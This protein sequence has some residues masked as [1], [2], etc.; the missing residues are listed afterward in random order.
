MP[1]PAPTPVPTPAPTPAPTPTPVNSV[2][3][4]DRDRSF[5]TRSA[6]S[7]LTFDLTAGTATGGTT[8]HSSLAISYNADSQSYTVAKG[9]VSSSFGQADIVADNAD[10]L[11]FYRQMGDIREY[12]TLV[13][14]P[15][16]GLPERKHVALGYWQRNIVSSDRQSM[17]LAT[18][19]YGLP[20]STGS[21]PRSGSAGYNIDAFGVVSQPGKEP[22]TLFGLGTFN[23]DFLTGDFTTK[24]DVFEQSLASEEHSSGVNFH[25]SGA[26]QISA[27]NSTFAGTLRYD[28][29]YGT[30]V[31]ALEGRFYGPGAVELGAAFSASN[32]D[33]MTVSGALTGQRDDAVPIRNL[34]LTNLQPGVAVDILGTVYPEGSISLNTDGSISFRAT[35]WDYLGGTFTDRDRVAARNVNFDAWRISNGG[36][37]LA[38][39]DLTVE[40][41]RP[42][43]D[44][45]ELALTYASFGEWQLTYY[46]AARDEHFPQQFIYGIET[47]AGLI[48]ARTGTARYDG[49]VLGTAS[50]AGQAYQANGTSRFD[51]NFSD[52][53]FAG[54]LAI[55]ATHGSDRIDFGSFDLSGRLNA[56][57]AD[58]EA[59]INMAGVDHGLG[60]LM[61]RFYGPS[62]QEIGGRF[63]IGLPEGTANAGWGITGVTVAKER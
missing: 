1:T 20:T 18:F 24:A 59:S 57:G 48:A 36:R 16:S 30:A 3:Y 9:E 12:L 60:T 38:R 17:D 41:Y 2:L 53:S 52:Q 29:L 40:L 37:G 56:L 25:M 6:N 23:A 19:V 10:E 43:A 55:A 58:S 5:T 63:T 27:T 15:Y 34:A 28:G 54:Q 7:D 21:M 62:A 51:I 39:E 42:G 45:T 44:N 11:V 61:F 47:P 35:E 33:G 22:R 26:G 50:N 4:P 32:A 46:D 14:R 31:G 8:R 13:R 49:V